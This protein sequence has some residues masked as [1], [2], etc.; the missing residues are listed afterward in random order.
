M[1][2]RKC[3][4]EHTGPAEAIRLSL[5][6]GFTAYFVL[7]PVTGLI[8]TVICKLAPANLALAPG[9]QDHTISPHASV[10]L[11]SRGFRVHGIPPRVR[12]D[13]DPSL[14]SGETFDH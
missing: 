2:T 11:V 8:A 1:C 13:R 5:R 14:S 3:A 6:D 4:H 9:R 10:T 12:D 7:S